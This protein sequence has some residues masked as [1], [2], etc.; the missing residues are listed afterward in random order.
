MSAKIKIC[1]I[2]DLTTAIKLVAQGIDFLGFHIVN[3]SD[4]HL[5]EKYSEI[6]S[7]LIEQL[8]FHNSVIV[9]KINAEDTI[10]KT[11]LSSNFNYI[12]FH[13]TLNPEVT[14][15]LK[16]YNGRKNFITIF[17]PGIG[18]KDYLNELQ[19]FSKYVIIDNIEGGLGKRIN[20]DKETLADYDN[21]FIAG[22]INL[23][24]IKG[25]YDQ[26]HPFGF[27]IQTSVEIDKGVKNFDYIGLIQNELS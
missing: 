11:L 16:A 13:Y 18:N 20:L 25:L 22:G 7:Y 4:L 10:V 26:F 24:N 1:R 21:I 14:R 27:D 12:Q 8:D 5:L 19:G 9:T 6:N 2:V 17:D 23:E 15:I 3:K